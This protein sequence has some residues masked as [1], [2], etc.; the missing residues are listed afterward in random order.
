MA[1]S[2]CLLASRS[3]NVVGVAWTVAA[4][5]AARATE[6]DATAATR[7][8]SDWQAAAWTPATMPAPHNTTSGR[9]C[10]A[11]L[12]PGEFRDHGGERLDVL[13]ADDHVAEPVLLASLR[14]GPR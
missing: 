12:R 7:Q 11:G 6:R 3:S 1:M 10:M 14:P 8:S 9:R 2:P 5:S 4:R 13:G